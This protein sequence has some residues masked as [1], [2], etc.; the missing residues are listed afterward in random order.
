VDPT[1]SSGSFSPENQLIDL[2]LFETLPSWELID[3]LSDTETL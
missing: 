1:I 3:E 2:G